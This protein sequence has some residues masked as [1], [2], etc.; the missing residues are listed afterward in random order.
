M[1]LN[2][3]DWADSHPQREERDLSTGFRGCGWWPER[4]GRIDFGPGCPCHHF[5]KVNDWVQGAS[6]GHARLEEAI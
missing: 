2:S 4:T 1:T 5:G 3:C 6:G